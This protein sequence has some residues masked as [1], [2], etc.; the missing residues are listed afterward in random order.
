MVQ[1][2]SAREDGEDIDGDRNA[3]NNNKEKFSYIPF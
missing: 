1:Q 2:R 3:R